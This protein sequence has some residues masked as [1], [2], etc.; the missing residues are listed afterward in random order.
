[1]R[2]ALV[3]FVAALGLPSLSAADVVVPIDS[4]QQ[5]VNIRA[6]AIADSDVIGRLY[7]GDNML[8]VQSIDGWHEIEIEPDLNGYISSD[9]TTV[10]TDVD[11][12]AVVADAGD[13]GEVP[14]ASEPEPAPTAKPVAEP[15]PESSPEEVVEEAAAEESVIEEPAPR[16]PIKAEEVEASAEVVEPVA[17][18]VPKPEAAES[19]VLIPGLPGP[20]G[21]QGEMGPSGPPGPP[22]PSGPP[23]PA[24]LEGS[25]NF[26][27]KFTGPMVGGTSQVYD[28]GRNIGIGTTEPKQR[29]EVNGNIQI[30]ER[31]SSVAGLIITQSSGETGYITHNRGST[32]TIGA[33]SVDRITIDGSGNVGIGQERPT[34]PLEMASGAHVTTGGAWT[35]NS[36]RRAK[37]NIADLTFEEALAVLAE[38]EPVRF[39]Y[40]VDAED[41]YIGFIAEDV[42]ELVAS[43]HRTGLSAMDIVAV[44]TKVVQAQ[45]ERIDELEA[46]LED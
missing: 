4:V 10:V 1:M 46:W 22:G 41:Q 29:L 12:E 20:Q 36:S 32:L 35:N 19:E 28:D 18:A 16:P 23:G 31:N 38:L 42:P 15:V 8:L 37:E 2:A 44:L 24:T 30:H 7:Q 6:E 13:A 3:L 17:D 45:Q 5:F 33:G 26:L 34:Q 43:K 25:A 9:W 27:T 11:A 40:K 14:E 39:N 21:P